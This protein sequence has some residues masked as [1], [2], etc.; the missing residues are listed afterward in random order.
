KP[1]QMRTLPTRMVSL[2]PPDPQGGVRLAREGETYR[3]ADIGEVNDSP[4]VQKA[5]RRLAAEKVATQ[6]AQLVMWN[7]AV[8]LDWETIAG[9]SRDWANRYELTLARDFVDR[10]E[11]S[12]DYETGC[13][14]FDI[15]GS[16]PAAGT[17]AAALKKAIEGKLVMGLRAELGV[18]E[19]PDRP[20]LACHVAIKGDEVQVQL[21]GTD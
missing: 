16:E 12:D 1:G 2:S 8:G 3:L 17:K 21:A 9:L 5:M 18:P 10:F 20:S 15:E 19:K 4:R 6:V 14:F 11:K 13:I 7:V